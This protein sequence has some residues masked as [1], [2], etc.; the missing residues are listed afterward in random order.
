M[1][2]TPPPF[3]ENSA[4]V[5]NLIFEPFKLSPSLTYR[6]FNKVCVGPIYDEQGLEQG[7]VPS[8]DC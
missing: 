4:K 5:I 6:E 1:G 3:A 2:G 7:G 8:S